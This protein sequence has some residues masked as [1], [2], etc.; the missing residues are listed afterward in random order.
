M[1]KVRLHLMLTLQLKE[2]EEEV[3]RKCMIGALACITAIALGSGCGNVGSHAAA[4]ETQTTNVEKC[5]VNKGVVA[6]AK[7]KTMPQGSTVS[8]VNEN[9]PSQLLAGKGSTVIHAGAYAGR[10]DLKR[11]VVADG[12]T[13]VGSKAFSGCSNVMYVFLPKSVQKIGKNVFADCPNVTVLAEKGIAKSVTDRLLDEELQFKMV[14]KNDT[15][16]I[17][18]K[19]NYPQEG[20]CWEYKGVR[21]RVIKKTDRVRLVTVAGINERSRK[22]LVIPAKIVLAKKAYKV[23]GI[24]K[25]ACKGMK[26]LTSVTIGKNVSS[27]GD[28]AFQGCKKLKTVKI[29]SKNCRFNGKQ[30]WKNT[31]NK[32]VVKVSAKASKKTVRSLQKSGIAKQVMETF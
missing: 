12:V 7:R 20:R 32:L 22:K 3:M 31:S 10:T 25:K 24:E 23:V 8:S 16:I 6:I 18:N 15:A 30:I 2:G 4:A 9:D 21:Y 1:L 17:L 28:K 5:P 13:T 14:G 29:L 26:K 11:I 19:I 27:I